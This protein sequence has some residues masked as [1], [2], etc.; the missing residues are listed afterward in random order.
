MARRAACGQRNDKVDEMKSKAW[1]VGGKRGGGY[2][3]IQHEESKKRKHS[4]TR[5]E[6]KGEYTTRRM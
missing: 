3:D 5:R 4:L 1:K 2:L 6:P